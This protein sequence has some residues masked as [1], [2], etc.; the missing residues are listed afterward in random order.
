MPGRSPH[1]AFWGT[2]PQLTRAREL[3]DLPGGPGPTATPLSGSIPTGQ[4]GP[5][6]P[7]EARG[8][9]GASARPS[10]PPSALPGAPQHSAPSRNPSAGPAHGRTEERGQRPSRPPGRARSRPLH[11]RGR[12]PPGLHL[13]AC[14]AGRGRWLRRAG[15]PRRHWREPAGRVT[16][17]R[18]PLSPVTQ[19]RPSR[20]SRS[21]P[22][23]PAPL[24]SSSSSPPPPARALPSRE[25]PG[26]A[27]GA[28]SQELGAAA[29]TRRR[30]HGRERRCCRCC[31]PGE[32]PHQ[33]F[34]EQGPRRGGRCGAGGDTRPGPASLR[35]PREEGPGP[36][37]GRAGGAAA[38]G[39]RERGGERP[40]GAGGGENARGGGV[41]FFFF[42]PPS[43]GR[44][45][46]GAEEAAG[47]RVGAAGPSAASAGGPPPPPPRFAGVWEGPLGP[48]QGRPAAGCTHP[49]P[50]RAPFLPHRS[51]LPP[52]L[53]APSCRLP[54]PALGGIG[55]W[56]GADNGAGC[57]L[58]RP[59]RAVMA[60]PPGPGAALPVPPCPAVPLP[61]AEACAGGRGRSHTPICLFTVYCAGRFCSLYCL[62]S[63][64]FFFFF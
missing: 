45:R 23:P 20:S 3:R 5:R 29:A 24:S 34:Q 54:A 16:C 22:L 25:P 37:P 2:N 51:V 15:G 48:G 39:R 9:G 42:S 60:L 62:K 44:G 6:A 53:P 52:R 10:P 64:F 32:P 27:A 11:V 38:G 49:H 31:R 17:A 26:A 35:R 4:A 50:P 63:T 14:S 57:L 43:C 41:Y 7:S 36:G 59:L 61:H 21:V 12:R 30:R 28:A 56:D 33:E 13:P 8:H 46:R 18:R 40:P 19:Q 58:C 1:A 47:G 55:G